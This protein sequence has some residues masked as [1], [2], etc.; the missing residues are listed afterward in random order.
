[1]KRIGLDSVVADM[2]TRRIVLIGTFALAAALG[3]GA[4]STSSAAPRKDLQQVAQQVREL[5][6]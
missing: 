5:Q 1:M 4:L 3:F 2:R 6:M